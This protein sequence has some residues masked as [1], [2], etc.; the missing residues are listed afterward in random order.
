M[1]IIAVSS[2]SPR[3]HF[4]VCS[5]STFIFLSIS[6]HLVTSVVVVLEGPNRDQS[7]MRLGAI[8]T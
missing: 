4:S 8:E 1:G 7:P 5:P 6:K 3:G 2:R